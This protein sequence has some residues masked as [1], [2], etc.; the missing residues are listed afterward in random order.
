[1]STRPRYSPCLVFLMALVIAGCGGDDERTETPSGPVPGG[2][3]VV[4]LAADP[5]VLNPLI[6]ESKI[7]AMIYDVLHDGLTEI[8]EN[9]EYR[10]RIAESWTVAPDGLSITYHLRPWNWSDGAPLTS[11]DVVFSFGLYKNPAVA[12]PRQGFYEDVQDAVA[13]DEATVR[14][15]LARPLPDVLERTWHHILPAHLLEGL[16]AEKIREWDFNHLPM[17]SGEFVMEEWNHNR[18]ISVVRNERYPGTRA[19]LDRVVFRVLPEEGSRL[20]ALETGE[21]DLVEGI[22]PDA[23]RRLEMNEDVVIET[24]GSRRYYYLQWNCRRPWFEDAPTRRALSLAVDRGRMIATLLPGFATPAIGPLPPVVWNHHATMEPDP[25]DPDRARMILAEAG[26]EDTDGDGILER[27]GRPFAIEI[28]TKQGDPV[29]ENGAVMLRTFLGDVGVEVRIRAMEL[30]AGLELIRE[31]R[32]DAYLGRLNAN[33]YGDPRGSVHSSAVEEFNTGRYANTAVDSLVDLALS[34]VDRDTARPLWF[35]VQ[36]LLVEDPPAAYLFYPS[37]L[38]GTSA[39]IR[40]VEP[41]ML[42]P[43]NN[44]KEWWIAPGDRRYTSG[45]S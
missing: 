34:I 33:L 37:N 16:D 25:Y 45:S 41:H 14:Y 31:G 7:A 1:M 23:A 30:A 29:R 40:D 12:S 36:E 22:P 21:V 8:D 27:E 24:T 28:L 10:P 5:D 35:E 17:S 20:V 26:W 43:I 38:V 4:A 42:S 19:L 6:H 9:L 44:L 13:L 3:A 18:S 15:D 11:R 39:R 32:F 2:T